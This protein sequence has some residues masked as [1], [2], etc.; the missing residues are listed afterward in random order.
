MDIKDYKKNVD[1]LNYVEEM[2]FQVNGLGK[3]IY[4]EDFE[5]LEIGFF[6]QHKK[7]ED[8][9][10]KELF[11]HNGQLFEEVKTPNGVMMMPV[12]NEDVYKD[13]STEKIIMVDKDIFFK[14]ID[15]MS[16]ELK[17]RKSVLTEVVNNSKVT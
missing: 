16:E 17:K 10:R 13:L 1:E 15:Y 7:K 11:E 6:I 2:M 12:R 3:H 14:F 9:K 4:E 8:R 5:K